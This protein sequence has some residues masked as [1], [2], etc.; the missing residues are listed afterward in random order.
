MDTTTRSGTALR[1]RMI[2]DMR[3]RKL[4]PRTR[5][6]YIRAVRELAAYLKRSPDTASVEELR[7]RSFQLQPRATRLS[8]AVTPRHGSKAVERSADPL[9]IVCTH[10][11][12]GRGGQYHEPVRTSVYPSISPQLREHV[13]ALPC[14]QR[15]RRR[16]HDRADQS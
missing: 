4:E 6:A 5:E 14:R 9:A 8:T 10:L 1:Q 7:M 12:N 13:H 2:D 11:C 3:K 15:S 16:H